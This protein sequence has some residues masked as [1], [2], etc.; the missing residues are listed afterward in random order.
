MSLPI[1]FEDVSQKGQQLL[2][3]HNPIKLPWVSDWLLFYANSAPLGHIIPKQQ[4]L[5][6]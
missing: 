3:K 1:L 6:W 5:I 2:S 4:I